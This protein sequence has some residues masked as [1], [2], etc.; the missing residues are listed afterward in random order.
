MPK[1]VWKLERFDGGINDASDP[2]D[3]ADNELHAC[4]GFMVNKKGKLR[5]A[6]G[7]D[8]HAA[9]GGD[10]PIGGTLSIAGY[11]LFAF[12][13][14]RYL[15]HNG[16]NT[17]LSGT[18]TSTDHSTIMTDT[19]GDWTNDELIGSVIKND[20]D[21]SQGLIT[22]NTNTTVTVSSLSGGSD[23]SWDNAD[24]D[25]YRIIPKETGDSY[26]LATSGGTAASINCYSFAE[27]AK[28]S[29]VVMDLG[30]AVD[31]VHPTFFI[32]E[33][34]VRV[35]NGN[36]GGGCKNKW[37]GYIERIDFSTSTN[38]A[39]YGLGLHSGWYSKDIDLAKPTTGLYGLIKFTDT[40][41]SDGST[42]HVGIVDGTGA[43]PF[44]NWGNIDDKHVVIST[45]G[46]NSSAWVNSQGTEDSIGTA[47]NSGDWANEAIQIYPKYGEGW[48]VYLQSSSTDG[49]WEGEHYKI[50]TTFIYQGNQESNILDIDD[51]GNKGTATGGLLLTA[52]KAIDVRVHAS[53][54]YDPFIIGGRVYIK[55]A[56]VPDDWALLADISLVNGVRP[57]L[58]SE[59]TAWTVNTTA[60]AIGTTQVSRYCSVDLGA[61]EN[62]SPW[63]YRSINGYKHDESVSLGD[64]GEGWASAVV[65]NR[66]TYVGNVMRTNEEGIL[67]HE[68]DAMYKSMPGKYDTFPRSRKI[69]ASVQDGD[70]IVKLEEYAD[71]ILQFKKKKMHLI[72][73]SQDVEFLEETFP[74]KGVDNPGAVCKTDFGVAWVNGNGI[75]L[76][77]G[78][79][80]LNLIEKNGATVI[81]NFHLWGANTPQIGYI[82][83]TRQILVTKGANNNVDGD[84]Y[85]FDIPTQ[86]WTYI[87]DTQTNSQYK[88]NFVVDGNNDLVFMQ[89]DGNCKKW[90]TTRKDQGVASLITKDVDF[91]QPSV[92][93][94]VYKVY[95]T[96]KGNTP[97]TDGD[98]PTI[99]YSLNGDNNTLM[100]FYRVTTP[101]T[102]TNALSIAKSDKTNSDTTPLSDGGS[103]GDY[104]TD[105]WVVAE[106]RPVNPIK[107]CFSIQLH[108][109]AKI[110]EE[111][112]INDISIIYRLKYV[113]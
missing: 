4:T 71:R 80:I 73:V 16:S 36:L 50:G 77:N 31:P 65:A 105:D 113:K 112:E 58:T 5:A 96:F 79:N 91:G 40:D 12:S 8:N 27:D 110:G 7:F 89:Q 62:P 99:Q 75:Y 69:L 76:Y 32:A 104:G 84:S 108:I 92:R 23:N 56:R 68:G 39:S 103:S 60:T 20:T 42:T 22:D 63:T 17:E 43:E 86:S 54:P 49:N 93:K 14:D 81:N 66:Q 106:L 21:G 3:I 72:N 15:A 57:D 47:T 87:E 46:S 102:A 24:D 82:P 25:K 41:H 6:S 51:H 34:A 55:K 67:V 1:Q 53:A 74:F 33:G 18:H 37:F 109:G 94:K 111:F 59:Y 19:S 28:G 2:R 83:K 29:V 90:A 97:H 10:A 38:A 48:N 78:Q 85:L 88:S 13:H 98:H 26:L 64:E 107:N 70:E 44:R 30:T 52:G 100:P 9:S 95:L 61:I 11:G 101:S 45:N 35:S